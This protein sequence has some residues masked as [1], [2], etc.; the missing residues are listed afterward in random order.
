MYTMADLPVESGLVK[1]GV[2]EVDGVGVAAELHIVT[3]CA[4]TQF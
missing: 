1:H 2:F 4:D 3:N